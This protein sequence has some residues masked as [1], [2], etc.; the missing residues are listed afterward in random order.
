MATNDA[1]NFAFSEYLTKLTPTLRA[2]IS[3]Y[4]TTY[5]REDMQGFLEHLDG[6]AKGY[7]AVLLA[8]EPGAPRARALHRL[9][10]EVMSTVRDVHPSCQHGCSACCH[11]EVEIT[12]DE[13]ALLASLVTSG[14]PIDAA[15][16]EAQ[17]AR[18]RL[19]AEWK[20]LKV[21]E[22]RCLFLG[23]QGACTVYVDRPAACRKLLVVSHPKECGTDGGQPTPIT[24]PLAEV[25][26]AR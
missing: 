19:S 23:P 4:H 11:Y 1:P 12:K 16:M 17:A 18:P 25:V 14:H 6:L 26:R 9:M 7:R 3:Q 22:N 5:S 2:I 13:G 21:P 24:I 8:A 20:K 15:R 10:E